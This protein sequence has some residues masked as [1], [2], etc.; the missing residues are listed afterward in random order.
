MLVIAM[1]VPMGVSVAVLVRGGVRMA[2][3]MRLCMP[4]L[5]TIAGMVMVR[6]MPVQQHVQQRASQEGLQARRGGVAERWHHLLGQHEADHGGQT[7]TDQGDDRH[8]TAERVAD[9]P[10]DRQAKR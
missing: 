7:H 2:V 4:G 5:K 9:Q 8:G 6:P 10:P 3:L 1:V